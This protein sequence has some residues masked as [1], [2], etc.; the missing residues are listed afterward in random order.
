MSTERAHGVIIASKGTVSVEEISSTGNGLILLQVPLLGPLIFQSC[1]QPSV[2]HWVKILL[3][4]KNYWCWW[5]FG[6][7]ASQY[8]LWS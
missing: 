5:V 4:A 8:R 3:A 1:S 2:F 7:N 6:S